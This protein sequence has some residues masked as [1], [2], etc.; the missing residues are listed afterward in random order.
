MEIWI[1]RIIPG[2]SRLLLFVAAG[3]YVGSLL[4]SSGWIQKLSF[5]ARPYC[6][7]GKLP[8]ICGAGFITAFASPRA[9]NSMLAGARSDE[10]ISR[11]EMIA[12]AVANILPS[13]LSHIRITALMIIP[14][15]GYAGAAYMGFQLLLGI[16]C[17]IAAL[18]ISRIRIGKGTEYAGAGDEKRDEKTSF[19]DAHRKAW[20]RTRKILL[21]VC[22]IS[23]PLYILVAYLDAYGIFQALAQ[24]MPAVVTDV[25]PPAS[26]VVVASHMVNIRHAAAAASEM[27]D[28]GTLTSAQVF[29]V[30]VIGYGLT[31]PIRSLR[32][33]IPS[34][35]GIFPG[36]DGIRIV[37]FSQSLRLIFTLL[38]AVS[39][40]LFIRI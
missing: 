26:F 29:L 4:E 39:I 15:L 28:S 17:T 21:R 3:V 9:A 30:L 12:G 8:Q 34:A 40:I 25:L 35:V 31:I 14:L 23:I 5:L 37:L 2:L 27:L 19:A 24:K 38:T 10:A 11:E 1:E 36:R 22:M 32:H 6:R 13:T 20:K 33:N 18:I 16:T 7:L